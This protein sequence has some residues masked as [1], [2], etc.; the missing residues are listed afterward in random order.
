MK[1]CRIC[2]QPLPPKSKAWYCP[3]CKKIKVREAASK[4]AKKKANR[5]KGD[6]DICARCGNE[7]I[8]ETPRQKYCPSCQ[9]VLGR[10]K[11]N[12]YT[13]KSLTK[14]HDRIKAIY[15]KL[16]QYGIMICRKC[17]K[18][19]DLGDD[20]TARICPDCNKVDYKT[21]GAP[22]GATTQCKRCGK[23]FVATYIS[24]RYCDDCSKI[25]YEEI[26][27]KA[28]KDS[29]DAD[30]KLLELFDGVMLDNYGAKSDLTGKRFGRL[31]AIGYLGNS[32]WRCLC[33][34]GNTADVKTYS[35]NNGLTMS[36]GC[37]SV[38]QA[39]INGKSAMIDLSNKHFGKLKVIRYAGHSKWE[40]LCECGNICYVSQNNLMRKNNPTRSCGC[41]VDISKAS[42][43][44]IVDGTNIGNIKSTKVSKNNKTTGVRGVCYIKSL[45]VYKAYIYF[46]HKRY[47]LKTSKNI[48]ECVK[49]RKEAEEKIFGNFLEWYENKKSED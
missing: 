30:N 43:A 4:Y 21:G 44:N 16:S 29:Y 1:Q 25:V 40:C 14:K 26:K 7:Y 33:D 34:C 41:L 35:L 37:L 10:D 5:N 8:I 22:I 11:L 6:K 28:A 31:T 42:K 20:K 12:E 19:F 39:K 27:S 38:E 24:N 49:A 17:G 45:G 36:C 9:S 32:K 23:D 13:R 3:E 18:V 15:D 47:D 48:N 2:G 46:Q